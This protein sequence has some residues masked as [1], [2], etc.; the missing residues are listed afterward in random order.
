MAPL[1]LADGS[2]DKD[3]VL[4]RFIEESI[5]MD[6]KIVDEVINRIKRYK[7]EYI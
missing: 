7:R 1:Y 3:M 2:F 5:N 4:E 6:Q